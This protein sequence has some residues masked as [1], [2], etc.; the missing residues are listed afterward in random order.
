MPS[1][2]ASSAGTRSDISRSISTW[3]SG[4]PKRTLYSISFGP[5]AVIIRPAKST[6]L[7]GAPIAFMART[8]GSTISS[9]ARRSIAAVIT[10]AG[11]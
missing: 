2:E 1:Q 4:S 6:P 5:A 11:E 8:V 10:G 7:N 3:H 9:I